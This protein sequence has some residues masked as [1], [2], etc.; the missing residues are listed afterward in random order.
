M[1][2]CRDFELS[3]VVLRETVAVATHAFESA[4]TPLRLNSIPA[5]SE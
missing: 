2:T 3:D 1:Q 4:N 5:W